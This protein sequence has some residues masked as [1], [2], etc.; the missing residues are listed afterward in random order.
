[1]AGIC[2]SGG[3]ACNG[4]KGSHVIAALGNKGNA[5]PVRFSFRR[6]NTKEEVDA[7]LSIIRKL[8]TTENAV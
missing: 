4:A 2:V 5:T 1:M 3:S 8:A 7:A 6:F